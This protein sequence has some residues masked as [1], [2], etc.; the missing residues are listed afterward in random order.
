MTE[1]SR[2]Y[3]MSKGAKAGICLQCS[4]DIKNTSA[5]E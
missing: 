1:C 3:K 4:V 2:E 5:G